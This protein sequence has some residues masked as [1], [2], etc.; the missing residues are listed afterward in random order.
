[1]DDNAEGDSLCVIDDAGNKFQASSSEDWR[2]YATLR[3]REESRCC[4]IFETYVCN[5]VISMLSTDGQ[6]SKCLIVSFLCCSL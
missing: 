2:D 5:P 6:N 3:L 1:M 4:T